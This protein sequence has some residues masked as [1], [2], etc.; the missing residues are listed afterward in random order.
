MGKALSVFGIILLFPAIENQVYCQEESINKQPAA[1][2]DFIESKRDEPDS[3][4]SPA[5]LE[6]RGF[7]LSERSPSMNNG[8]SRDSEQA[9]PSDLAMPLGSLFL[10]GLG[11]WTNDKYFSA[12]VYTGFAIGGISTALYEQKHHRASEAD[13]ENEL[14]LTSKNFTKRKIALGLQT[15]QTMGGLSLYH[16]FI[17]STD[18]YRSFSTKYQFLRNQTSIRDLALAP[19]NFKNLQRPSTVIPLIIAGVLGS[20]ATTN[21]NETTE[22]SKITATDLMFSSSF[23]WNASTHEE[24]IFR[25]W[26]MPVLREYWVSSQ[27]ANVIQSGAFAAAHLQSNDRPIPQLL[28]GW[29][30]GNVTQAND[31]SIEESV[32]IH[33]W[34]DVIL[35]T[36]AYSQVRKKDTIQEPVS[37]HLPPLRLDF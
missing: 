31:W 1:L 20:V 25:G 5:K 23:S 21:H 14:G 12:S 8:V 2:S 34:W 29:H 16:T 7:A 28:L 10:P 24:A 32:F 27:V 15:Y 37:I 30:L 19:F 26:M 4:G 6:A 36:A 33:A 13:T 22:A 17:D 3:L 35:L 11:Q 9:L 18:K